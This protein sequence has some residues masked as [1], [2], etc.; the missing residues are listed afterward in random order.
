MKR[1]GTMETKKIWSK[2]FIL[3]V[4]GQIISIFGNTILRFALPLYLLSETGS[5]ALF[6]IVTAIA[7]IPMIIISPIGG[8]IADRVN[9][10]NIMVI[11]DFVTSLLVVTFMIAMG[12]VDAVLLI[13]VTMIILYGIQ[14][15]Y[16]PAVQASV[17][18]LLTGEK[19]MQGNAIINLVN[20]FAGLIGPVIGGAL[21]SAFGIMPILCV[22]ASCFFAS[23]VMEMFICIPHEKKKS[24][25]NIFSVGFADLKDSINYMT[26]QQPIIFK[27]CL[28]F[29]SVN[30]FLSSLAVIAIPVIVTQILGFSPEVGSKL[31]GY[32][33]GAFAAGS[34][35]GGMAA[36]I[37]ATKFRAKTGYLTI[38][39]DTL[40]FIPIGIVLM[41]PMKAMI[42]YIVI[43]VSCL[44]MMIFATLVSVQMMSYLQLITP[45]HLL[46]KIIAGVM[47]ISMCATPLGQAMYGLLF[48]IMKG[49]L[50]IVIFAGATITAI[51]ALASKGVFA[52]LDE[53]I[54]LKTN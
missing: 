46:G 11:L 41:I 51:I 22:S 37:F 40:T 50:H 4:I 23:A 14:G 44:F 53:H 17:P 1:E 36:G 47:C 3:V 15:A 28:V 54:K 43:V 8:V 24:E 21:F 20:L 32:A 7:F 29:A 38:F 42:A 25:G 34:L 26:K 52:K 31:Y 18:A 19:I 49:H 2:D 13:L 48:E 10:R 12:K 39:I 5:A 33:E 9:K 35:L 45:D 30:L 16:S 27:A 6:G